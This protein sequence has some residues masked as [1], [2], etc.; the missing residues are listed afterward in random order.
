MWGQ[1]VRRR[2]VDNILAEIDALVKEHNVCYISFKDDRFFPDLVWL[3]DFC[4]RLHDRKYDLRF[5]CSACP[6]DFK[7]HG[8]EKINLLKKAGCDALIFGLQSTNKE[9]LKKIHRNPNEVEI[10]KPIIKYANKVG[11]F[12]ILE[13]I[14]GLPGDTYESLESNIK[15]ALQVKPY[16]VQFN[17]LMVLRGSELYSHKEKPICN[18]TSKQIKRIT[19]KGYLRFYLH[20]KILYKNIV[21]VLRHNPRWFFYA[22]ML[23]RYPFR[24]LRNYRSNRSTSVEGEYESGF[25]KLAKTPS[26][27]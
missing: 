15:Y 16:L 4:N 12:T 27:T 23:W 17:R 19:L 3:R 1:N 5:N 7:D 9:I 2:S 20:P 18:L 25:H 14:F 8:E 6:S 10:L 21:Y 11:L 22:L 13:F 24:I 26:K